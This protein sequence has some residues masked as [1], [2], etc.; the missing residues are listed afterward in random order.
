MLFEQHVPRALG[1]LRRIVGKF[2]PHRR[3]PPVAGNR[4]NQMSVDDNPQPVAPGV[5]GEPAAHFKGLQ[6]Q[7]QELLQ[8][9]NED[10]VGLIHVEA[11]VA[12]DLVPLVHLTGNLSP[13]DPAAGGLAQRLHAHVVAPV[14]RLLEPEQVVLA[15][16]FLQRHDLFEA[17]T[18]VGV[19]GH[20]PA[21]VDVDH[22]R[23]VRV[24]RLAHPRQCLDVR[25]FRGPPEA[26]LQRLIA[27]RLIG[28]RHLREHRGIAQ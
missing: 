19:P 6:A 14:Q 15:S 10:H 7:F 24:D 9:A 23:H 1:E 4:R 22:D 26:Q 12:H 28:L 27:L 8:T 21:M 20:A 16:P 3:L 13:G 2:K 17:R 11:V 25:V 18:G 5:R